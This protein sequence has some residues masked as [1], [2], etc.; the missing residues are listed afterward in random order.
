MV[1]DEALKLFNNIY[2]NDSMPRTRVRFSLAHELGHIVLGH[3]DYLVPENEAEANYF[4]SCLLAPRMAIHY[5]KCKN[6]ND[7]AK[8]FNI[9][10]E[11]ARYAFMDYRRWHRKVA[12]HKMNEL[13]KAMYAHF[14]N[15]DAN[16]FVYKIKHCVYCDT[17]IYN[18]TNIICKKCNT[19]HKTY[20]Q[21]PDEDLLIAEGH[22]LYGE[23]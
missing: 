13:D 18:S 19:P 21:H 17:P 1:S 2:Y 4:S 5:S 7:V 22:W 20:F 9:S 14:Y 11:A 23:L 8:I 15:Q 6:E 3:G 10:S 16:R 12:I